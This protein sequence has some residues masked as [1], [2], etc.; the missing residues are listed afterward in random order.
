[1]AQGVFCMNKNASSFFVLPLRKNRV[2]KMKKGISLISFVCIVFY[3][4]YQRT[5]E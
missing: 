5:V 4:P 2:I 1:M 3:S